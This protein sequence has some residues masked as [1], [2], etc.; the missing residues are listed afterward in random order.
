MLYEY[1]TEY[2]R[3]HSAMCY[4]EELNS[5]G[6]TWLSFNTSIVYQLRCL[7]VKAMDSQSKGREFESRCW[8]KNFSFCKSRFR[9]LQLE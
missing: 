7:A 2:T 4:H 9:S 6:K 5:T 1:N 3:K 8:Q